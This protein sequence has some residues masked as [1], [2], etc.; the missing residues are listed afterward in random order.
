M[1]QL[2][3]PTDSPVGGGLFSDLDRPL[4]VAVE[5]NQRSEKHGFGL[6]VRV[7]GRQALRM[8]SRGHSWSRKVVLGAILD[9][10]NH[11]LTCGS[12][13]GRGGAVSEMCLSTECTCLS[14]CACQLF[15]PACQ[16]LFVILMHLP[17]PP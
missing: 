15:A 3:A 7:G 13:A 12:V 6:D 11:F 17:L 4:K 5:V 2:N 10:S 16:V 14:G 8:L 9:S 1:C